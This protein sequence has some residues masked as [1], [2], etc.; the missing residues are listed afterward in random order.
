[1]VF[2]LY[3][4]VG[5]K[6]WDVQKDQQ[7]E[8]KSLSQER[9]AITELRIAFEKE[10]SL[11]TVEQAKRDLELQKRE[12]LVS[13]TEADVNKQQLDVVSREKAVLES[14]QQLREGQQQFSKEQQV[15]A[16]EGQIQKI[17]SEFAELGVNLNDNYLCM[18]GEALRRFYS[19]R[20]KFSQIYTLVNANF[21]AAKYGD[22]IKQNMPTHKWSG[23]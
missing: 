11:F 5:W 9:I 22:F 19:A 15:A 13:R 12:F 10:K 17:M 6:L 16:A 7:A 8:A 1:V 18:N 14:T 4:G 3:A 23:C 20:A 2:T 21:L